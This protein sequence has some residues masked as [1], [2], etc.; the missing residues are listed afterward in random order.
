MRNGAGGEEKG[1]WEKSGLQ[2]IE[3]AKIKTWNRESR[4]DTHGRK[5]C[6]RAVSIENLIHF[7]KWFQFF[8]EGQDL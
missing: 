8:S 4:V 1:R 5:W 6:E 2:E 7:P 3:K